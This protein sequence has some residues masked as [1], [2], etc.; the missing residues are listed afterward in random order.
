MQHLP[1]HHPQA[2]YTL[3]EL[4]IVLIIIGLIAGSVIVG[5]DL[6]RRAQVQSLLIDAKTFTGAAKNFYAQYNAL[7][8][9]KF[10]ANSHWPSASN[11]D[12][13]GFIDPPTTGV[14]PSEPYQ[15]WLHLQLSGELAIRMTGANGGANIVWTPNSN[16]PGSKIDNTGW[17]VGYDLALVPDAFAVPASHYLMIGATAPGVFTEFAPAPFLTPGEALGLDIKVDDGEPATG[18]FVALFY[19]VGECTEPESGV[20]AE[21]NFDVRYRAYDENPRCAIAFLNAF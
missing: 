4:G 7:P 2:G 16:V 19:N 13:D 12:G 10:D 3:V 18:N 21:D 15:F 17:L 11:G 14:T 6:I 1:R 5:Q 20:A 9:D 8:G